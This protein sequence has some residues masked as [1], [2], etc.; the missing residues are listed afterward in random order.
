MVLRKL[1]KSLFSS[2]LLSFCFVALCAT[3]FPVTFDFGGKD[4]VVVGRDGSDFVI[5][6]K[7]P[8][9]TWAREPI[10]KSVCTTRSRQLMLRGLHKVLCSN[11][12]Q[13]VELS[14]VLVRKQ[15]VSAGVFEI[16]F[17]VPERGLKVVDR[18][19]ETTDRAPTDTAVGEK[20][21]DG[22]APVRPNL[23]TGQIVEGRSN[24]GNAAVLE[25]QNDFLRSEVVGLQ[26]QKPSESA[27]V[28][29]FKGEPSVPSPEG[30][31]VQRKGSDPGV[32]SPPI[33]KAQADTAPP[34]NNPPQKENGIVSTSGG[35]PASGSSPAKLT[36][37]NLQGVKAPTGFDD[38]S[39]TVKS[40]AETISFL[41]ETF[42][43]SVKGVLAVWESEYA[44]GASLGQSAI[45]SMGKDL[46]AMMKEFRKD[47]SSVVLSFD[48]RD[49]LESHLNALEA[50]GYERIVG[51]IR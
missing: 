48:E 11:S 12:S 39:S 30:L 18:R 35:V 8:F 47:C 5:S 21:T 34:V 13:V 37:P 36:I 2:Y 22:S 1:I 17:V 49:L 25:R 41:R 26:K 50:D 20:R 40:F 27:L 4:V 51:L 45:E 38:L 29:G 24:T 28:S 33:S 42:T 15:K 3:T 10:V 9:G 19:G 32:N 7:T 44:V 14:G 43:L 16:E 31:G 46:A 6:V 23:P